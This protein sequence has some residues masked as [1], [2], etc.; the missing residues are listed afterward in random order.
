MYGTR[1]E[2]FSKLDLDA[3]VHRGVELHAPVLTRGWGRVLEHLDDDAVVALVD[4]HLADGE[5]RTGRCA[6]RRVEQAVQRGSSEPVA[7]RHSR[8]RSM[9][10]SVAERRR[11]SVA[12]R[13]ASFRFGRQQEHHHR[14][15]ARTSRSFL[16]TKSGSPGGRCSAAGGGTRAFARQPRSKSW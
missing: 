16:G 1:T 12:P 2:I 15:P 14:V 13:D 10:N 8:C 7:A 5:V 11:S 6:A 4:R 9:P 3:G